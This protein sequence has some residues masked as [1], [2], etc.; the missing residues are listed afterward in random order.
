ALY[1]PLPQGATV[2]SYALDV[3]GQL[4]DGVVV[5]KDKGRQVFETEVRKGVDPGLVEW[6]RG[7]NFKTRIFPIPARGS[8][9]IR[10]GYVSEV[11]DSGT[12]ASY[13]LPLNFRKRVKSFSLRLEV[14]RAAAKPVVSKGGP[15]GLRFRSA[16]DSYV[17]T[18]SLRNA[19]LTD[20]LIIALPDLRKRPVRV[21]RAGDGRHYFAIRNAV[22]LPRAAGRPAPLVPRRLAIYWDASLS[23]AKVAR[24]QELA[25]LRRYLTGLGRAA[26]R[27]DVVIIR[28]RAERPRRFQLPA[29]RDQLLAS[30]RAVQYDGGTQ[31]GSLGA[32]RDADLN[33]VFSDGLSTFGADRPD[34]LRAPTFV[35][36]GATTA[37]HAFLRYLGVSTGGAYFNLQ[38]VKADSAVAGIGRQ[39]FSFIRA[40]ARGAQLDGLYPRLRTPVTGDD[41]RGVFNLAGVLTAAEATITLHYGIGDRVTHRQSFTVRRTDAGSGDIL[42]RYWAQKKV[43]DLLVFPEEN[44]Q[45]I[46]AVGREHSLVTPGTS[47][48]VL[49]RL[50]Q[51]IEH[52]VRPPAMLAEMRRQY[53]RTM[54]QQLRIARDAEASKLRSVLTMWE[55][56]K[57]W[58]NKR[59]KYP[60]NFRYGAKSDKKMRGARA[61]DRTQARPRRTRAASQAP[62][63]EAEMAADDADGGGGAPGDAERKDKEKNGKGAGRPEPA[64]ALKPWDP[65]MPYVNALKQAPTAKRFAV[66]LAQRDRFGTSPAFYLDSADF[67]RQRGQ[68]TTALQ[69]LSNLAELELENPALQR[70]LA[71]RLAQLDYLDLSIQMFEQVLELR[72]EEPQSYRD[73]A[74]ILAR[75]ADSSRDRRVARADYGRALELLGKVVMGNWARFAEIEVMALTELNNIWPR[76]RKLGVSDPRVDRRLIE[77]LDM[78]IRIVMTWD[79]DQ[80]DM[81][82]HVI[83]P[84]GEEAYY[85]HNRTTIGGLVSRDFT[86]G[87]G[88]EVYAVRRAMKGRYTIK[89]KF[90]GSSAAKLI[91]AVTLQ[92]DVYTNY[93]RPNEK[94]RSIT[95]RLTER[96]E[97]FTV[98]E[99]TF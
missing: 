64:I 99:I 28:D 4:V 91:G 36:N 72:P 42:R 95:L 77:H 47:L 7:N 55:A 68:R 39:V 57:A 96:K 27:A 59:Y 97:T 23:R 9:T 19:K 21:E 65:D 48:L 84:S 61:E 92:V 46:V 16:R 79:A 88:P 62:M 11:V 52:Q 37:N 14:V 33:L 15:R 24:D 30:L 86:Q 50:D 17:A 1:F 98:G 75:R 71:H 89:T 66:Y 2:S 67:F 83:E 20:D 78:D 22:P 74:L 25:V 87:Y 58:W 35:I 10:V 69:I 40:E 70:V 90:F 3:N 8:R 56:R 44:E 32:V 34:R 5:S 80:T 26:V 12:R 41:G 81:D 43:D 38:R 93:V 49:E 29:Q 18:A 63:E 31:L 51:Y 53:D 82:L 6:T 94:R 54:K 60:K 76:A 85:G 73:L 13:R 45:A